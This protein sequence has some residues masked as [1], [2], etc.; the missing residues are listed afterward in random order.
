MLQKELLHALR[1]L[2]ADLEVIRRVQVD[3]REG[4][5]GA[6]HVKAVPVDHLDFFSTRLFGPASVQFNAVPQD[7]FVRG[8]L[9]ER[10]T[11]PDARIERATLFVRECQE[12][13]APLRL[14]DRKRVEPQ[15]L[16]SG[17]AHRTPPVSVPRFP[18]KSNL[19]RLGHQL[20]DFT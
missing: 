18:P 15:T 7:P 5:H 13:T 9:S 12:S 16:T 1:F 4:F 19:V 10:S 8:D 20:R 6:L 14:W 3:Q 2:F 17:K 11:I